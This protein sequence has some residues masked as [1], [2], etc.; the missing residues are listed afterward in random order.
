MICFDFSVDYEQPANDGQIEN[1]KSSTFATFVEDGI[2]KIKSK[3]DSKIVFPSA[4]ESI[5]NQENEEFYEGDFAIGK[6]LLCKIWYYTFYSSVKVFDGSAIQSI[7]WINNFVT[8]IIK[9]SNKISMD[10]ITFNWNMKD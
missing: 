5:K 10:Y 9:K 8:T 6:L 1:A 7:V 2:S 3:S 4:F